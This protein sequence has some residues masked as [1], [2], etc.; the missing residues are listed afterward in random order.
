M[1]SI[2]GIV[3]MRGA[4]TMTCKYARKVYGGKVMCD[5]PEARACEVCELETMQTC[6]LYEEK[7]EGVA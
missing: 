6:G 2:V 1:G 5:H 3:E 7:V 4:K